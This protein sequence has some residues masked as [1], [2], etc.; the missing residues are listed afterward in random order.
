LLNESKYVKQ[1]R[2]IK[3]FVKRKGATIMV[4]SEDVITWEESRQLTAKFEENLKSLNEE[5]LAETLA[6]VGILAI[7]CKPH[8]LGFELNHTEEIQMIFVDESG[9]AA[10]K[11]FKNG[12]TGYSTLRRSL[13][14]L[15]RNKYDLVAIPRSNDTIDADRYD[16]FALQ[17]A[18]DKVLTNWMQENLHI[19][20]L[21]VEK[22][23]IMGT[24]QGLI[25]YNVPVFNLR[26][27]REN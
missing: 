4:V 2:F 21:P 19:A 16:N 1:T 23:K 17:D 7:Y 22:D 3:I 5:S 6:T 11:H 9:S 10:E 20:V 15:L 14:A 27:N 13:A 25:N 24:V 12:K 18:S 26:N 8:A